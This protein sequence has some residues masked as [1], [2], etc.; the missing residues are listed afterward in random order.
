M[1][2][3][4]KEILIEEAVSAFRER[5]SSGRILSSPAWWDLSPEDREELLKR[6]IQSRIMERATS[7]GGMSSTVRSVLNRIWSR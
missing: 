4:P 6:Q 2:D 1:T 5:T 7:P 3:D